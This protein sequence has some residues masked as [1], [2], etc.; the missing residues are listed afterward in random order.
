[1]NRNEQFK[2]TFKNF[3][4]NNRLEV[5]LESQKL[6]RTNCIDNARFPLSQFNDSFFNLKKPFIDIEKIFKKSTQSDIHDFIMN[7]FHNIVTKLISCG[8]DLIQFEREMFTLESVEKILLVLFSLDPQY[9]TIKLIHYLVFFKP[10]MKQVLLQHLGLQKLEN[11]V[12]DKFYSNRDLVWDILGALMIDI[13]DTELNIFFFNIWNKCI[14]LQ[15]QDKTLNNSNIAVICSIL[16]FLKIESKN[17]Y[18][19]NINEMKFLNYMKENIDKLTDETRE[20]IMTIFT[21]IEFIDN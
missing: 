14:G 6:N 16:L 13:Y 9:Y 8:T 5:K 11:F 19:F 2:K 18:I 1:M 12:L 3:N 4:V 7:S 20:K 17:K 21:I 10:L 15:G